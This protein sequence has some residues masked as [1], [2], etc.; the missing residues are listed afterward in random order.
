MLRLNDWSVCILSMVN[1]T[2]DADS[3][4]FQE[5]YS[6]KEFIQALRELG[7]GGTNAVADKLDCPYRT[8][9]DRLTALEE[10]GKIDTKRVGRTNFWE[11]SEPGE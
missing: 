1:D 9:Y 3:G 5:K 10:A 6:D 7:G 11:V 2:R 4:K 8:T